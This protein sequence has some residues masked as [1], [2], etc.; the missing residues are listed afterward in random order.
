MPPTLSVKDYYRSIHV[1]QR[2]REYC[3]LDSDGMAGTCEFVVGQTGQGR[4]GTTWDDAPHL[5]SASLDSL[6]DH[7]AD[8]SRSL[9]TG[10]GLLVHI[11]LDYTNLDFPAEPFTHPTEVFVK[12]ET[13]Y[14]AVSELLRD[15]GIRACDLLTGEGYHFSA[16]L[17][18]T[19]P[20]FPLL[21]SMARVPRWFDSHAARIPAWME[22]RMDETTARASAGLGRVLEYAAHAILRRASRSPIPVVIDATIVGAGLLGREFVSIDLSHAAYP[23]DVRHLRT[24]FSAYQKH[25][26]RPDVYGARVASL[27]PALASV[28]RRGGPLLDALATGRDLGAAEALASSETG[29]IPEA[30]GGLGSLT[31]EYLASPLYEFHQRFEREMANGPSGR[32]D[33][34]RLDPTTLPPCVATCL[35][36][37]NDLLLRPEYL[38][39]LM[40]TLLARDWTPPRIARVVEAVYQADH[41]WGDRWVRMLPEWRAEVY[42]RCFAGMVASG[43]DRMTDFNCRSTQEKGMCPG[44]SCGHEL[45]EDRARVLK[46]VTA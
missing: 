35:R 41:G 3:G 8:V 45:L 16:F 28:P 30:G 40:R 6:L 4:R 10:E 2:I 37:P 25:R 27:V 13:A 14:R 7:G 33:L 5:P 11:D 44:G 36:T 32:D 23:L 43:V 29:I 39:N 12:L 18:R 31:R 21:A 9:W 26:F 15:W 38:Q 17:P 34:D 24:A 19:H 20:T 46:E 42:V 1:R 22:T